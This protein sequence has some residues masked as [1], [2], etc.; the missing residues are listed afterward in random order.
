ML[1]GE[2][3]EAALKPLLQQAG[4]NSPGDFGKALGIC[5]KAMAG[6]AEGKAVAEAVKRLLNG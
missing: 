3:L 6:K 5:S 2:D 4:A 1:E